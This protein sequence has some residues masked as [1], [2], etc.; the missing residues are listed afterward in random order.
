MRWAGHVTCLGDER[1]AYWVL[2]GKPEGRRPIRRPCHRWEDNI[3]IDIWKVVCRGMYCVDLNQNA[4][5][6]WAPVNAVL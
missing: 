6:C 5:I 2:V 3:K 4:D 1:G